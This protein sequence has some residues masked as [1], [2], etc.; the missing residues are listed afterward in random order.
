M[1]LDMKRNV[2][3]L[4]GAFMLLLYGCGTQSIR[5][6]PVDDGLYFDA[7]VEENLNRTKAAERE[8][9]AAELKAATEAAL[10]KENITPQTQVAPTPTES[11]SEN[12][13]T[14]SGES[15]Y[16]RSFVFDDPTVVIL[17]RDR[18]SDPW[19]SPYSY[20][21]WSWGFRYSYRS[22]WRSNFYLGFNSYNPYFGGWYD[23]WDPYG[24]YFGGYYGWYGIP[25]YGSHGHYH[26]GY[27]GHNYS[28][29]TYS[30]TKRERMGANPNSNLQNEHYMG[31]N[32]YSSGPRNTVG[33]TSNS[34][35][36]TRINTSNHSGSINRPATIPLD[37][38]IDAS[39]GSNYRRPANTT[40]PSTGSQVYTRPSSSRDAY[41]SSKSSTPAIERPIRRST[42]GSETSGTK[43]ETQTRKSREF[44]SGDYNTSPRS[45]Y[46]GG[47][48][49][50]SESKSTPSN[51]GS[52]RRR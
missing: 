19:F 6:S 41:N 31:V 46:S 45:N 44:S 18:W 36:G 22:Y 35:T 51:N 48:N 34:S 24:G 38:N 32:S 49:S 4:L 29:K 1:H 40:K 9:K 13:D 30:T 33:T 21:S 27:Y 8:A 28:Y 39:N 52:G 37:G 14:E 26:G 42:G 23:P 10:A 2:L 12:I 25:Y 3:T 15:Q 47:S 11:V 20:P 16:A 50:S 5:T 43:T 17:Y 7:K